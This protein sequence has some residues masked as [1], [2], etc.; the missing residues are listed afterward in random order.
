MILKL[1]VVILNYNVRYFLELCLQS[2]EAALVIFLQKSLLLII[3]LKDD[4]CAM[5]KANFPSVT[6][7]KNTSNIGFSKANNQAVKVAKGNVCLYS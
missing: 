2:V 1:S 7:I 5:V 6:L 3:I 4:S